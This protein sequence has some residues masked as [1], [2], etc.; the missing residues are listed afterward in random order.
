MDGCSGRITQ[1][2]SIQDAHIDRLSTAK[3]RDNALDSVRPFL[4]LSVCLSVCAITADS[5]DLAAWLSSTILVRNNPGIVQG[6]PAKRV[7]FYKCL[8]I[9][10]TADAVDRL[11]FTDCS[12]FGQVL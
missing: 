7:W 10:S 6:K 12:E 2:R 11:L 1:S 4:C 8:L 9:I 5:F 3:Q